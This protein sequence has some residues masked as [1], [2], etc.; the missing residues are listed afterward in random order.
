MPTPVALPGAVA[1]ARGFVGGANIRDA[2]ILMANN[3]ARPIENIVLD[4]RGGGRK[5]RGCLSHGTFGVEATRMLSC[6]TFYR[7][8][9]VVPQVIIHTTDG[10]LLYTAAPDAVP[11]VWTEMATG[12]STTAPM[13]YET[14]LGKVYM[15][16][17]V[18]QYCSWSG[19]AFQQFPSAPR[20][21][22]LR[23]WSDSMWVAGVTGEN[24]RV[25]RAD[26][27]S[28]EV[29]TIAA[30]VDIGAGDGDHIR[31]LMAM[32][33]Q[34]I[35]GKRDATWVVYDPVEFFNRVVDDRVG[36][37]SHTA[38]I[39]YEGTIY[40]LSRHG[41][42][43]FVGDAP[44]AQLS[45]RIEPLFTSEMIALD[46]LWQAT[47]YSVLNRIAF[48]IPEAGQTRN[49]LVVEY[50]PRLGASTTTA[51]RSIGP[52]TFHRMPTHCFTN[53]R[54][55]T[56][57]ILFAGHNNANKFLH[58]FAPVGTDDGVAY[59]AMLQTAWFNFDNPIHTKYLREMRFLCGGR[60]QV[61]I[62]RNFD[63][64][65]YRTLLIDAKTIP[66]IWETHELW[67]EGDWGKEDPVREIRKTNIDGYGR[68]FSFR[69]QDS[70]ETDVS[71]QT[72]WIGSKGRDLVLGEWSIYGFVAEGTVLGKRS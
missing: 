41:I 55:G 64:Q 40:F 38:G 3:E 15:G 7:G 54:W 58:V 4:E 71:F 63:E 51:Q 67:G 65:V 18:D 16:N 20:G 28:A 62:Y 25:Y 50:Y 56:K 44:N 34:L 21:R 72:Y 61:L 1:M 60:F 59:Q 48:A 53:W 24:D 37:E 8:A 17:G 33:Q 26:K 12:L 35:V 6:Y 22:Y 66:D 27:G 32:G 9:G 29:F 11:V 10:K 52:M 14:A 43:Q 47:C 19:S 2:S 30:W 5:R 13:N 46:Q 23:F 68:Y 36:F 31:A 42:F 69:F 49:T 70:Y 57:D 45:D 39:Q